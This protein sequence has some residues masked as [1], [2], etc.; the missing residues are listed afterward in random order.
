[1]GNNNKTTIRSEILL[2]AES[3]LV[4]ILAGLFA[5]LY[6]YLLTWAESGLGFVLDQIRG[7]IFSILLWFAA[8]LIMGCAVGFLMRW[9]GMAAGSGIPQVA[10][11]LKGQLDPCWWRV[12]LAKIAGGT[13]SI[14]GGLSLGREGPSVQLGAMAA[15][16]YSRFRGHSKSDELIYISCGAGAGLAAAF[17][18]PL[19]GMLFA[20]EEPWLLTTTFL[21]PRKTEP[22]SLA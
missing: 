19:A 7:N 15:K 5:V 21:R 12:L 4:G 17:N 1:M 2:L 11:E 10:G 22:P 13:V 14:F 18:A 20:L 3:A 6:R 9:E 16:G 8:L